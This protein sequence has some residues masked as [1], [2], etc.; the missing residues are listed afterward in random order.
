[1]CRVEQRAF[2][3]CNTS[4]YASWEKNVIESFVKKNIPHQHWCLTNT[5]TRR[6]ILNDTI[7]VGSKENMK[8]GHFNQR[9]IGKNWHL[10]RNKPQKIFE[11][12]CQ[13]KMMCQNHQ[14]CGN[15]RTTLLQN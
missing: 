8:T 13:F 6:K 15:F 4:E 3:C 14:L 12:S 10:N 9:E 11:P 7:T 1:M 2:V 5:Y